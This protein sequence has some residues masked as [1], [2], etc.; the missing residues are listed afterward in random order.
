MN[1]IGFQLSLFKLIFITITY[2]SSGNISLEN[3]LN[4]TYS[5]YLTTLFNKQKIAQ[6]VAG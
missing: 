5:K 3:E 2:V 1:E 6:A 4:I